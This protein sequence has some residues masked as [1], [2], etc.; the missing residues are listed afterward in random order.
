MAFQIIDL[1]CNYMKNPI[2]MD[3]TPHF[4][5]RLEGGSEKEKLQAYQLVVRT[6]SYVVWDSGRVEE[7]KQ[8]FIK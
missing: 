8:I 7:D 1:T 2:G 5:Y 4:S 3:D 6:E